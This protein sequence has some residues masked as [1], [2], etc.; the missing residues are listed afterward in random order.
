MDN[1]EFDN[2]P[3]PYVPEMS[4]M[5]EETHKR[6]SH[7][8]INQVS[9]VTATAIKKITDSHEGPVT[10]NFNS[11]HVAIQ[12]VPDMG[13][14]G[15]SWGRF[16]PAAIPADMSMDDLSLIAFMQKLPEPRIKYLVNY[17]YDL[18]FNHFGRSRYAAA[19]WLGCSYR[20][21]YRNP[22]RPELQALDK[23]ERGK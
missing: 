15:S 14:P 5:R 9:T 2:V 12:G 8:V 16:D 10:I 19:E 6:S 21:L 11:H 17:V 1:D 20:T 13:R 23:D 18:A 22:R 7:T 4:E 3:T